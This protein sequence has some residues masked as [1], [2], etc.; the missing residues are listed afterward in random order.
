V[1]SLSERLKIGKK[2]AK[3]SGYVFLSAIFLKGI[4]IF[5]SIIVARL[6]GPE[7]LGIYVV[8]TKMEVV[9]TTIAIFGM[10]LALVR[11]LP[12]YKVKNPEK[13]DRSLSTFFW[14]SIMT[15]IPVLF[16]YFIITPYIAIHLYNEPELVYLIYLSIIAMFIST[17]TYIFN[18]ILQAYQKIPL[19]AK[20]TLVFGIVNIVS[21][22]IMV[23]LFRLPGMFYG[24][25]IGGAVSLVIYLFIFRKHIKARFHKLFTFDKKIARYLLFFG[26]PN[27]ISALLYVIS[28]WYGVTILQRYSSF[29]KVGFFNVANSVSMLVTFIPTAIIIPLLPVLTEIY[30]KNKNEFEQIFYRSLKYVAL[31]CFPISLGVGFF[32]YSIITIIYSDRFVGA[33]SLLIIFSAYG[34]I[35]SYIM[36]FG[37]IFFIMK[38][39]KRLIIVNSIFFVILISLI[40]ILVPQ[41][42][43]MGLVTAIFVANSIHIFNATYFIL[44]NN[45]NNKLIIYGINI[46]LLALIILLVSFVGS[47]LDVIWKIP[48]YIA[49]LGVYYFLLNKKILTKGDKKYFKEIIQS[50]KRK[51]IG[52]PNDSVNNS[53]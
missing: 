31:I 28:N 24:L 7:N 45:D 12:E 40:T 16:I 46:C 29:D 32:N 17:F 3:F 52:K 2:V 26:L 30:S 13:V 48:I 51:L 20:L 25:I 10:P 21:V 14:L 53:G 34:F 41:L 5:R 23:Y 49:I 4:M 1:K 44:Q 37:W 8:A 22:I 36:V 9:I 33:S 38:E 11:I 47:K 50:F 43:P 18:P 6:L 27:F 15:T 42:G 35:F 19:M 39:M